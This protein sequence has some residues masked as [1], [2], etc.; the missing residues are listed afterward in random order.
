[1]HYLQLSVA[2]VAIFYGLAETIRELQASRRPKVA[3][4]G[5]K[6]APVARQFASFGKAA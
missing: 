3:M 4:Y 6:A 5:R 2:G 1:M